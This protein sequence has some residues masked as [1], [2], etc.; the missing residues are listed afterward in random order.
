MKRTGRPISRPEALRIAQEILERAERERI[1]VA[2]EEA[3]RGLQ[4]EK[5]TT[6]LLDLFCGAVGSFSQKPTRRLSR[7]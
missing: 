7:S 6:R 5:G 2:Q 1:E 4:M 3:M